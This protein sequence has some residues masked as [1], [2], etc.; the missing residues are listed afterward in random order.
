MSDSQNMID[1]G[2]YTLSET[3]LRIKLTNKGMFI[4]GK[5]SNEKL[6]SLLKDKLVQR[7]KIKSLPVYTNAQYDVS[8]NK[9]LHFIIHSGI[10]NESVLLELEGKGIAT[11]FPFGIFPFFIILHIE[12]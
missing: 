11:S 3:K 9:S 1:E 7:D 2:A 5:W 10:Y 8:F 12:R 4:Y 6:L